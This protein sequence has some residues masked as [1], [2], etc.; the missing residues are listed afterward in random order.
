MTVD[1]TR[2]AT[3][4][5]QLEQYNWMAIINRYDDRLEDAARQAGR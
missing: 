2:Q 5:G 3:L 4:R 1:R